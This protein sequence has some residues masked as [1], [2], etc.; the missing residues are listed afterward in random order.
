MLTHA[1]CHR[2]GAILRIRRDDDAED[3]GEELGDE[4]AQRARADDDLPVLHL[5][6][7][8][9]RA[10][11]AREQLRL[12]RRRERTHA[13][14]HRGRAGG[15]IRRRLACRRLD[16]LQHDLERARA[17]RAEPSRPRGRV[18]LVRLRRRKHSLQKLVA[19][20]RLGHMRE[21]H[22]AVAK[23][24]RLQQRG[25]DIGRVPVLVCGAVR[26]QHR[27]KA[28]N[29]RPRNAPHRRCLAAILA[30]L[31]CDCTRVGDRQRALQRL[32]DGV[33]A[34]VRDKLREQR[35]ATRREKGDHL[36]PLLPRQ[37]HHDLA[38]VPCQRAIN[39]RRLVENRKERS[40]E[41]EL[42]IDERGVELRDVAANHFRAHVRVL[43][44]LLRWRALRGADRYV[45]H[46]RRQRFRLDEEVQ[47]CTV[48]PLCFLQ[49]LIHV[50]QVFERETTLPLKHVA[51]G[52]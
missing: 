20:R 26:V 4:D 9:P 7:C 30:A 28:L 6:H 10:L 50:E 37:K 44:H 19:P 39:R 33:R 1:A 23:L 21:E 45:L 41:G 36:R 32:C 52:V 49:D 34:N 29:E 47:Q 35:V 14:R 13:R 46:H 17:H 11:Q 31:S 27:G 22:G 3:D 18:A 40:E 38:K 42:G 16:E 12:P 5:T 24:R 25:E 43:V 15:V 2:C 48:H 51:D 8:A